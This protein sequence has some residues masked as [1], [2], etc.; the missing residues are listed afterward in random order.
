MGPYTTVK[1]NGKKKRIPI[2]QHVDIFVEK[3]SEEHAI[4]VQEL[5]VYK[6]K[7]KIK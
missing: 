6:V 5:N 2:T 4:N 1:V 3:W 7:E